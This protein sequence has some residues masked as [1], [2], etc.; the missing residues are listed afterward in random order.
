MSVGVPGRGCVSEDRTQI[1]SPISSGSLL[2]GESLIFGSFT[3]T[4]DEAGRVDINLLASPA[5]TIF[6]GILAFVIDRHSGFCVCVRSLQQITSAAS[7]S[8]T[9]PSPPALGSRGIFRIQNAAT[10]D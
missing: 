6:F 5:R 8:F 2:P 4:A 1:G 3:F 9:M 7:P 10:A